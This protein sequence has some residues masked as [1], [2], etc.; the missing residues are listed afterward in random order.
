MNNNFKNFWFPLIISG[1]IV[2]LLNRYKIINKVP[3]LDNLLSKP[4]LAGFIA[5]VLLIIIFWVLLVLTGRRITVAREKIV[6]NLVANRIDRIDKDKQVDSY[7]I[8]TLGDVYKSSSIRHR[9]S[10]LHDPLSKTINPEWSALL[11]SGQSNLDAL[12]TQISYGP[13]RAL[14][15]ALPGLGFMGTAY[16]MATAIAGLGSSLAKTQSY[17]DLRNL[18]VSGVIPHLGGAFDITLFALGSS[19]V[20]FFVLSLVYQ[21]E[22]K[23]TNDS[24]DTI[25][26]ILAQA[27]QDILSM[28]DFNV[29]VDRLSREVT[30][31]NQQFDQYITV[32]AQANQM[33]IYTPLLQSMENMNNN[34]SRIQESV[35]G[36]KYELNQDLVLKRVSLR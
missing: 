1:V 4:G 13:L 9:L 25:L 15:W 6:V 28:R 30:S 24:D 21:F 7:F 35:E 29:G 14:V 19:V 20:L 32:M 5:L 10:L 33:D 11:V 26:K 16:E 18:L 22:E 12:H 8:V 27:K 34:L 36:L 2:A 3:F 31:F 17:N 23:V